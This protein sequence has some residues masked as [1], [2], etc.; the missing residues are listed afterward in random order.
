[1]T[2]RFLLDTNVVSEPTKPSPSLAVLSR[3][4]RHS[5]ECAIP[6]VVW[7]ELHYG[8]ARLPRAKRRN[9][10]ARYVQNVIGAEF[11]IIPY[12]EAA[13]RWHANAR[14][15]V[16]RRGRTPPY[17]DGQIA[18]IAAVDGLTL[19]TRNIADFKDF[20]GLQLENWFDD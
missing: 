8:V 14:A 15:E 16:A 10:L 12:G 17:S 2:V 4:D 5:H 6:S 3:L 7:H 11:E 18:A 13:A 1:M 9:R 19:V 20:E